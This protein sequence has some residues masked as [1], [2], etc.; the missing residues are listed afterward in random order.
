VCPFIYPHKH[1]NFFVPSTQKVWSVSAFAEEAA[2]CL[3]HTST[4]KPSFQYRKCRVRD[5]EPYRGYT[6]TSNENEILTVYVHSE[7]LYL[8]HMGYNHDASVQEGSSSRH[9]KDMKVPIC[10]QFCFVSN[11]V[12]MTVFFSSERLLSEFHIEVV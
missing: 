9:L 10:N 12:K 11:N 4:L 2:Y 3:S 6:Q 1:A 5:T 7:A 8:G